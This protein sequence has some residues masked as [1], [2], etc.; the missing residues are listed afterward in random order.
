[1]KFL[2]DILRK[3]KKN[4]L[5]QLHDLILKIFSLKIVKWGLVALVVLLFIPGIFFFINRPS[6]QTDIE[7]GVNFSDK[8]AEEMGMDWK[9][10]YTKILDDL[11][12]QNIRLV[13][14]WDEIEYIRDQYDHTNIEWQV[15]EAKKRNID[16]IVAVG[17]KVPRWP[18][19]FEPSWWKEISDESTRE[20][21]LLEYVK[22]TVNYL[23][24]YDN[25][26]VWQIENEPFFPFGTC[27]PFKESTLKKE[28]AMVRTLDNRPILTQDSGEGGL[29]FK[30]Y[31]NS[32]YL[33]IS[34]YR[35]IWYDFWGLFFGRSIYFQYPLAYWSYK[36][37]AAAFGI[38]Y[39]NIIVTELQSEPWGPLP[40]HMLSDEERDKTMSRSDFLST[41]SYAQKAGF[42]S[43]YFWGAEWWLWQKEM[44]N[45]PFYWNTAKSL[46]N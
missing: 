5:Q 20:V 14:Y 25:V 4:Q 6:V 33:G 41:I 11:R 26:K 36:I 7:Y 32:D 28:I 31:A 15:Q 45:E 22:D 9:D 3:K 46:F 13:A 18:E 24:P 29:W 19:C 43:Y 35:K 2:P 17:K 37:K 39:E 40:N 8:Y 1:M 44:N 38:P 42:K 10:A 16:V 23:R 30:S 12:P 27:S 34:M 21:E